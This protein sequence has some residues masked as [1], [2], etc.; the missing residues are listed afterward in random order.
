MNRI[1]LVG[2][3]GFILLFLLQGKAYSQEYL[4]QKFYATSLG[5]D[6]I[7]NW[8]VKPGSGISEFIIQRKM[9]GEP[10]FQTV[11]SLN[12][13]SN[14][15]VYDYM[16]QTIFKSSPNTIQYRLTILK[17]GVP[18]YYDTFITLNPTSAQ[19]TWGSIKSMFR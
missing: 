15:W 17:Q 9:N 4:I 18:Y 6:V 8:E 3:L 12:F 2:M 10:G 5:T 14:K 16:D 7:L 11:T 13:I 19:R 1:T